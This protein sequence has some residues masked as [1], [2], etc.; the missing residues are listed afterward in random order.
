MI[1]R[2]IGKIGRK[3]GVPRVTRKNEWIKKLKG[4]GRG[5]LGKMGFQ[6]TTLSRSMCI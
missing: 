3:R 1:M 2:D 6:F 5:R 4:E